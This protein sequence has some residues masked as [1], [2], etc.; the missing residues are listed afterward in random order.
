V[1]REGRRGKLCSLLTER[2]FFSSPLLSSHFP[3]Q[4]DERRENPRSLGA[5]TGFDPSLFSLLIQKTLEN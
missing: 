1:K 4:G 2:R 5:K 3:K